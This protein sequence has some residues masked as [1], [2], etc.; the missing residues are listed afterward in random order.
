MPS[1]DTMTVLNEQDARAGGLM[2]DKLE[3]HGLPEVYEAVGG[4][5]RINDL[6]AEIVKTRNI[7]L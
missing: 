6:T 7:D 4:A 5:G 1:D 2:L 3:D